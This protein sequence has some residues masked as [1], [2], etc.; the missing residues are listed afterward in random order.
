MDTNLRPLTL[1]E[2]L[3]RT[4]QLYRENFLLFAGIAA[5]YAGVLLV[6]S[7]I[8]IGIQEWMRVHHMVN[9][10]LWTT[11][12]G[13]LV[14]WTAI[15]IFGGLAVAA[16]NRAVAWVHLGETATIRGA[17]ASIMPRVGRYL[18]LM[19]ITAFRVWTPC[20]VLY[21]GYIGLAVFYLRS[22]GVFN[23]HATTPDP[24]AMLIF[25]LATLAFGVLMLVAIVYAILMAL[26]YSL[27]V[28][29]CVVEDLKA[30]EAIR[31][32]IDLSKG[33]RGRIFVLGLL[34]IAIQIGLALVTQ[35]FFIV[36]TFK[37]HGLLPVGLRA[38]QQVVAFCT[39]AFVG[40][41]YATGLTLFYYDQRVRTEGF[42]IERMMQAAG[43]TSS[44]EPVHAYRVTE[45]VLEIP[46]ETAP[47]ASLPEPGR[48]NE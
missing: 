27:A 43:L 23:K 5:V 10:L 21:L 33:T 16:N 39:N 1:G 12:V 36:A 38:L 6:L 29:A 19:A 20:A 3:D 37:H 14:L 11:G 22:K 40:P 15:F 7:L 28:P 32:S 26:R 31:R 18:W 13:V 46:V 4:A 25:G 35:L 24:S 44:D 45:T 30:R 47:S 34:A 42:D 41:I 48:L 8:Q 17:Y 2:I 9:Q